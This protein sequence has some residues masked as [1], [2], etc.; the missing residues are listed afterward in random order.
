MDQSVSLGHEVVQS[1]LLPVEVIGISIYTK[2][3][4][5]RCFRH[6]H[7]GLRV[8]R[9]SVEPLMQFVYHDTHCFLANAFGFHLVVGGKLS[10]RGLEVTEKH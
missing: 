3:N 8:R 4:G 10:K 1:L 2:P 7:C 5:Q 6:G 9:L